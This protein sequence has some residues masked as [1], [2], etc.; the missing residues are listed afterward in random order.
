MG[1]DLLGNESGRVTVSCGTTCNAVRYARRWLD[2]PAD[3]HMEQSS[4]DAQNIEPGSA[5]IKHTAAA[6]VKLNFDVGTR[7]ETLKIGRRNRTLNLAQPL[8]D[9]VVGSITLAKARE[10]LEHALEISAIWL[11]S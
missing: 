6:N 11:S 2:F 5:R 8:G 4:W 9:P 7:G 1:R 3:R 10:I